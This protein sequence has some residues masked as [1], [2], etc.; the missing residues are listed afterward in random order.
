MTWR[1]KMTVQ[2]LERILWRLR[3][4]MSK[5]HNYVTNMELRRAIMLEC[6]TDERTIKKH[7]KALINLGWAKTAGTQAIELTNADLTGDY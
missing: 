3:S 2:Q 5:G 6:G 4:K 7:R 1:A